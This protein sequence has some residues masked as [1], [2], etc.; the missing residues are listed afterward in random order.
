MSDWKEY[1]IGDICDTQTGPF[2]SQLHNKDYVEEGTPIVTVEHLGTKNFTEQNLPY[3][4]EDDRVRLSKYAMI[5]GDV[6]FSRVGS[7]DRCS[8]VSKLYD[9]WLFSGRC[10]RVRPLD[11]NLLDGSFLY[12]HFTNEKIKTFI[13]NIAVGATMPSINTKLMNEVP[14]SLPPLAE[15]KKIAGILSALD[16]KIETNR[17]INARLEEMAQTL[18]KSW[19]E[20]CQD[21]VRIGDIANN[22]LDYTPN[23]R[24]KVRLINSSDVTEG[25]FENYPLVENNDLKGHFKKR[26]QKED[27]LYS[28]IRPRNHHYGYALMDG[29]EYIVSTRFMVIR[30]IP[31]KVTSAILY[32]YLLLPE[33]EADFTAKTESRS[34]TFPQG[35][36]RD[37]ETIKVPYSPN[38]DEINAILKN[39]RY[40]QFSL[41]QESARLAA[42]RDTLL[43]KLMSGE[44][45]P[46]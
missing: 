2:G 40:K 24:K 11:T 28:E 13:R 7:V 17:R 45:K 5:E 12:Y 23:I 27:I 42:L 16:E 44:L 19:L 3:V 43:P 20:K 25:E 34:G 14:I 36:Y 22:I 29:D 9:G 21:W 30:N 39:I 10:L 35:T 1:R 6:I 37:M 41:H 8:Y 32:Q 18:F 4:S 46:K 15:Q 38:Q 26:F 33:V 31:E